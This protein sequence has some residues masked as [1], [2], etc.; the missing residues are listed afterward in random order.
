MP[1]EVDEEF[2][3]FSDSSTI[4]KPSVRS[5]KFRSRFPW[6]PVRRRRASDSS[7]KG[8]VEKYHKLFADHAGAA[9]APDGRCD[10]EVVDLRRQ[11]GEERAG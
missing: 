4:G 11:Q 3:A 10:V 6:R 9:L 5:A 7:P 2:E 8:L 1:T